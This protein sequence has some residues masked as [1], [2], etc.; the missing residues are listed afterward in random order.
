MNVATQSAEARPLVHMDLEPSA[1]AAD[2]K[3]CDQLANYLA[4]IASFDRPDTFLYSNLLS[5]VLNELLEVAFFNHQPSGTLKCSLLRKGATD[6]IELNIP[7]N[8]E[9]RGFYERGVS[10]AQSNRV[11]ELY[12]SSLRGDRPLDRSIGFLELAANYGAQI[13]LN[14]TGTENLITL[15]VDVRLDEAPAQA[16][17]SAPSPSR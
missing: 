12:A 14:G 8:G 7:V 1:F 15:S 9:I 2:W 10:D 16:G 17:T 4:R 5:T 3:H 6:R 13:S 11:T